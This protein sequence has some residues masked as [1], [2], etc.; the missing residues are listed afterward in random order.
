LDAIL[1]RQYEG[2]GLGLAIVHRLVELFNGK[3]HVLSTPGEGSSF[4]I[5]LP[6]QPPVE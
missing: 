6:W 2:T 3:I 1:A 5:C 4:I